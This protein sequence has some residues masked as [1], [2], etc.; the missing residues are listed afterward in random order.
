[1]S[2]NYRI[3]AKPVECMNDVCTLY[4]IAEI[5]Y[6]EDGVMIGHTEESVVGWFSSPKDLIEMLTIMLEEAKADHPIVDYQFD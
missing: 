1:M 4:G 6:D 5:Y 2:W 3:I